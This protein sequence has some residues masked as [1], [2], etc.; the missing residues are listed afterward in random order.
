MFK[1]F[2][3]K[4]QG[5]SL[6][7]SFFDREFYLSSNEDVRE[8]DIDAVEHYMTFGFKENRNPTQWFDVKFYLDQNPDVQKNGGDPFLHFLTFGWQEKRLPND[9]TTISFY[10]KIIT[11]EDLRKHVLEIGANSATGTEISPK[12]VI[13]AN[14]AFDEDYYL[15]HLPDEENIDEV[16]ADALEHY[17]NYGWKKGYNPNNWFDVKEYL[18]LN[19][20]IKRKGIEP[21]G[22]YLAYGKKEGR[23]TSINEGSLP[24]F[25]VDNMA[26][27]NIERIK[28]PEDENHYVSYFEN[29]PLD[30]PIKTIAFYLPQFH[31]FKENDEW[32]GKGFTEW[33]NVTKAKPNFDGHYQPHLPIHNGFYDLRV[34]EVMIEQAKMAKNYGIYGFNYYYYWFDGKILMDLPLKNML[35]NKEIDIPFCL[36]WANENW[37]RRWDGAEHDVLIA[38]NHCEEDSIAFI[39]NLFEYF[40]DERYIRIDDKPLLIIY[41]ANIIPDIKKM[42]KL[43]REEALK[44][45][46]KGLYIVSAQ[47]F[48]ATTPDEFDFDASMEFPPHTVKS[49]EITEQLNIT[50]PDFEGHVFNY[51]TVVKTAIS[52]PEPKYDLYRTTM[53]GWDNTARKQNNSH[54]FHNFTTCRFKQWLSHTVNDVYNN[55]KYSHKMVF[56]NAWNEW[57][58]G[59]HLEPDREF[60]YA[61]LDTVHSVV[62][63]YS[64][65]ITQKIYPQKKIEKQHDIGVILHLHYLD[66]WEEISEYLSNFEENGFDL[67][68]SLTQ[69]DQNIVNRILEKYPNATIFL[70]ENRGRDIYPFIRILKLIIE[71]GYTA[72]CK[73]HSKKSVYRE[74]GSKIKD[75]LFNTL[76]GSQEQIN[77]ILSMF[78]DDPSTGLIVPKKY[79]IPHSRRNMKYHH[80]MIVALEKIFKKEFVDSSFPAGSMYW[81][82]PIA[83]KELC[84]IESQ[85]IPVEDGWTDGTI[86]HAI[87]RF[88]EVLVEANQHK[89]IELEEVNQ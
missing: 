59:T 29:T 68:I 70:F 62:S 78:K 45:G 35:K 73:V 60:G 83:L 32:W 19:P 79:N 82:K 9:Y 25:P 37:T 65:D 28:N 13:Q 67:Y 33:T 58:E 23:W 57:A 69:T 47:T 43:W 89:V 2:K 27:E 5:Y 4:D 72:V 85:H 22:H 14:H 86:M 48:G 3:R 20:D 52:S 74:D 26:R 31:P 61:S 16:E 56:V 1:K 87:E 63:Q 55:E 71:L 80:Q 38:Q 36:T 76:L 42:A 44:E 6:V 50:N 81:F 51:D 53:L 54:I 17:L 66:L 7:S 75:E 30:T 21:F 12:H 15:D 24:F 11:L 8:N 88:I 40:H 46:F 64:T 84:M 39:H 18:K 34:Q 41:R 10:D 49:N 77:N